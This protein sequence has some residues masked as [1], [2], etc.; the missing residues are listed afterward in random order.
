MDS[1]DSR[2]MPMAVVEITSMQTLLRSTM[3][4]LPRTIRIMVVS[5]VAALAAVVDLTSL[6]VI[7]ESSMAEAVDVEEAEV[8]LEGVDTEVMADSMEI[9][10]D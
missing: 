6:E 4:S 5:I 7:R 1:K 10:T 2:G 3:T 8:D 9:P